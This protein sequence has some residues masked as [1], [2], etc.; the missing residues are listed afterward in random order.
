ML[1]TKLSP[2]PTLNKTTVHP[3][4]LQAE[5][6]VAPSKLQGLPI[7]LDYDGTCRVPS[8]QD[9]VS[10]PILLLNFGITWLW[11]L[12]VA[13]KKSSTLESESPQLT[14][15]CHRS[16][17]FR[18]VPTIFYSV[19]IWTQEVV[20]FL[21]QGEIND[22]ISTPSTYILSTHAREK[23]CST[24]TGQYV[25]KSLFFWISPG[26]MINPKR[27]TRIPAPTI[28]SNLLFKAFML[29]LAICIAFLL[30]LCFWLRQGCV[31]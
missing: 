13:I 12:G 11:Q 19:R 10:A 8:V 24:K 23:R 14:N 21:W 1:P 20:L 16:I 5:G 6:A 7:N 9:P 26:P 18:L 15:V 22:I 3:P 29:V 27:V 2:M 4:C 25:Y 17:I 28:Y 30:S 31:S